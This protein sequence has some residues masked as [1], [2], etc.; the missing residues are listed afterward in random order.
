MKKTRKK[1]FIFLLPLVISCNAPKDE[2]FAIPPGI[3]PADTF[4]RILADFALAES[5]ANMNIKNVPVQKIDTVYAFDP[6][7]ENNITKARYDSTLAFYSHHAALYKKVYEQA[8]VLLSEMESEK[9]A[10]KKDSVSR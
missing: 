2:D 6:L 3:L 4:S 5:A 9:K 7:K 8:L 1:I 10:I